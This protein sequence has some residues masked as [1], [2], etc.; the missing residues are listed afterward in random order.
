MHLGRA[1]DSPNKNTGVNPE[2]I[3][4]LIKLTYNS[5]NNVPENN[6]M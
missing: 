5:N 4:Q 6:T 2:L 3:V 1:R